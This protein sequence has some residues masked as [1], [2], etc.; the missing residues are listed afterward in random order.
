MAFLCQRVDL[1]VVETQEEIRLGFSA[2][3]NALDAIRKNTNIAEQNLGSALRMVE[4]IVAWLRLNM[5]GQ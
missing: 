3:S 2:T 4:Q 1:S 5:P